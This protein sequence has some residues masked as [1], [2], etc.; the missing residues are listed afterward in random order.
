[1]HRQ[2][3]PLSCEAAALKMAMGVLGVAVSEE[4]LLDTMARDAT[5]R[6]AMPDGRV[7]WGDPDLGYVGRWDGVFARDGYGVY[8]KPIADL[9]LAHGF[10]GTQYGRGYDPKELY[11][12]VRQGFPVVVWAP[13]ELTVK[14]RGSWYTPAGKRVDYVVTMH[15][16]VLAGVDAEGVYYADPLKPTLQKA[17]YAAFEAAF[18]EIDRRAVILRP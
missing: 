6:Q 1:M 10:K 7:V 12:A 14:G 16:M 11:A 3:H 17:P 18:T 13:Y 5:P 9:A 2:E 4:S 15:A 8:E